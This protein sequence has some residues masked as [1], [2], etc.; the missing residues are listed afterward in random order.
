[1]ART[2]EEEQRRRRIQPAAPKTRADRSVEVPPTVGEFDTSSLEP[3]E[4]GI[5]KT[6]IDFRAEEFDRVILQHGKRVVW[7]K[8]LICPC[9]NAESGQA[10]LGC[11]DCNADGFIYVQPQLIS[12]HMVSFDKS[13]RL[14]E[15]MGL[16]Q[17]GS[18]SVTTSAKYRLGYRDSLEM[19]DS[20]V[21]FNEVLTKG[22]RRGRRSVLP[23]NTDSARFRVLSVAALVAK[24]GD[25]LLFGQESIHYAI[26][27]EG[28]LR[29]T[30]EGDRLIPDGTS[31]TLHYDFHPIFQVISHM[32][33]T[34]DDL[35][36]RNTDPGS[37]RVVSLPVQSLAKLDFLIDVNG[38]PSMDQS[39][40]E[41][42]GFGPGSV[43]SRGL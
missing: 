23:A 33:V 8:A 36:G 10:Q 34:R 18:A 31:F 3:L 6:R 17:E 29:W 24:P 30:N 15:K 20:V 22:N 12:A 2:P 27:P 16:M 38:V 4:R 5:G 7:R 11:P 35:S 25:M 40:P 39:V 19:I 14:Y 41:A 26:T 42:T 21:P 1:M 13:T 43:P 9:L 32:H 37:A 28:W